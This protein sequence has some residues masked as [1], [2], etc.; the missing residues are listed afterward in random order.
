M[1]LSI[2]APPL[3][4]LLPAP[5]LRMLLPALP[6]PLIAAVPVR[7][8]FSM[9]GKAARLKVMLDSILSVPSLAFSVI[10]SVALSTM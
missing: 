2:P 7:V 3:R 6:V 8:R 10:V 4:M 1:R 5:L 9:F